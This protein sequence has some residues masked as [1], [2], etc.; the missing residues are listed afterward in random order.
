M[1]VLYSVYFEWIMRGARSSSDRS[2]KLTKKF[3]KKLTTEQNAAA[4]TH[5]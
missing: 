4:K 3:I 2:Q 1:D 5:P